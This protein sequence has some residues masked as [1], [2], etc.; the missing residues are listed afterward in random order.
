MTLG[1]VFVDTGAWIAL[2]DPQDRHHGT[3]AET[4]SPLIHTCRSLVTSNHVVGETYTYLRLA[5]SYAAAERF[6]EVLAQTTKLERHFVTEALEREAYR[7]LDRYAD[8]SFSFV[9]ATSFALMRQERL[10][11][12]FAFDAHFA[13]AGFVRIPRD[14]RLPA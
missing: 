6:L 1:R 5:K 10:R 2:Q 12:A 4:F 8:H 3:A 13:T 14:L 11:Y 9:D 7:I